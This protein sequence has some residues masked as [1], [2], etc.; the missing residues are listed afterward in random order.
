MYTRTEVFTF[1]L[2]FI[3][4]EILQIVV[5]RYERKRE[6]LKWY[7]IGLLSYFKMKPNELVTSV[8]LYYKTPLTTKAGT[9]YAKMHLK[10]AK[11]AANLYRLTCSLDL[12]E[13]LIIFRKVV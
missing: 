2:I 10:Q 1:V 8:G 4:L 13:E 6:K 7:Y 11:K 5:T 12:Y 3:I 9:R